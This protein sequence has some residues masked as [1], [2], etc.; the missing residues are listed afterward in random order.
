MI[1][2][3]F[4]ETPAA[5]SPPTTP[6][7]P[8][9]PPSRWWPWLILLGSLALGAVATFH[10]HTVV[11]EY[12]RTQELEVARRKAAEWPRLLDNISGRISGLAFAPGR[13]DGDTERFQEGAAGLRKAFPGALR[14]ALLYQPTPARDTLPFRAAPTAFPPTYEVAAVAPGLPAGAP[15]LL[16]SVL[17]APLTS[18][19]ANQR[20]AITHDL[21]ASGPDGRPALVLVAAYRPLGESVPRAIH[22]LTFDA[23]IL[24][25]QALGVDLAPML[26]PPDAL[27]LPHPPDTLRLP[28][29]A[30][31]GNGWHLQLRVPPQ[32][33]S[34]WLTAL[35][36]VAGIILISLGSLGALLLRARRE[37][38]E[39]ALSYAR[40]ATQVSDFNQA[41]LLGFI[42]LSADWL[43]ETDA[44]HRFTLVS[45]GILN[46]ARL[47]P[48]AIVGKTPWELEFLNTDEGARSD[49]RARFEAH[50]AIRLTRSLRN[51]EGQVRRLELSGKP[52]FDADRFLGYRGVGRDVTE[53]IAAEEALRVSEARFRDLVELSSDWYWEQDAQFR[54]T[55]LTSNPHNPRPTQFSALLGRTRWDVAEASAT[56]PVWSAHINTLMCH[57][58]FNNFE[59]Q[60]NWFDGRP[61][62]FS[63]SG[64]PLFDAAG[65]FIGYRGVSTDITDERIAQSALTESETRYR[66][67]FEHAPVGIATLSP[68]GTWQTVNDTL[69]EILGRRRGDL[70]GNRYEAITHADDQEKDRQDL[71]KLAEGDLHTASREKRFLGQDGS[72]IWTRVTLSAQYDSYGTTRGLICVVEDITDRIAALQA[73]RASEERYR[74]LLD[75]APDGIILQRDG[76]IQFANPASVT[77]LGAQAESDLVGRSFLDQVDTD[78]RPQ[79]EAHF[80]TLSGLDGGRHVPPHHVRL[81]RVDGTAVDVESSAV[82]IELDYRPA[83]L[84]IVRDITERQAASQALVESQSRYKDVVESVNEVIFRTDDRGRFAFLNQAWNRITGFRVEDS[85]GRSL[86]DFLHPDDRARARNTLEQVLAGT[87]PDCHA[88][89]R[90]RTRDGQIRWIESAMRRAV[91]AEGDGS[92]IFGSLDDISSRKIA[93]LTLRNLN[94][95][96]EA[97]VRLRTAELENSNRELEAFSYSVS[98]DLRAPLRAIDGFAHIIEEDYADHIDPAGRA[99]LVRIRTATHRMA[100]LIDDL[101]ELARLTRQALRREHVDVSELA[102]QIVDELRAENPERV[103][104]FQI[105]QGLTANADRALIRVVFENLLRNAWKFTARVPRAEVS[106][107]GER[108]DGK[109]VYCVSD[110][111]V[112]FDMAFA[113]KLFRPFHRLHG[114]AEFSGSGIG[115]ATVERVIQRHGGRVWAESKPNAGARFY[116]TL[117]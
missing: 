31:G 37:D 66:N 116:F 60:S 78:F 18:R 76:I 81:R 107:T 2:G 73:L 69:C 33:G 9:T 91:T 23:Q 12:C 7:T 3:Y 82:A 70:V 92:G 112:G 90:I 86:V 47:D 25:E 16:G 26:L 99:Y 84:S 35:P 11:V 28:L 100:A 83:V 98:H 106:V 51:L 21:Q 41:R 46:V 59:Y 53:R 93:E 74:R 34:R 57:R 30:A 77:L 110:N 15:E 94:Q 48:E 63:V 67:T 97:R 4:R 111:G 6:S 64:R 62:W 89:L 80:E 68:G 1:G 5:L 20:G 115:L 39:F 40:S 105:T 38:V 52:I 17:P 114:S 56:D 72:I 101:I 104:D 36:W 87:R 10:L 102:G 108:V 96:L 24:V 8:V 19:L 117:G 54:Y 22:V 113:N 27:A 55:A 71:R 103:V 14:N 88:E 75:L 109:L 50:E 43:W 79:E 13:I 61:I 45:N 44:N 42:E 65:R 95:E 29:E 85:L 49:D 58:P 32:P